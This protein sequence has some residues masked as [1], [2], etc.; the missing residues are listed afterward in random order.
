MKQYAERER[1]RDK[2]ASQIKSSLESALIVSKMLLNL[3]WA[4]SMQSMLL[5]H[6]APV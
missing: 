4:I 2:T 6:E 5:H 1:E 3:N